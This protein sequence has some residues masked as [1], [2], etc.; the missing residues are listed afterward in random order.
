M[1]NNNRLLLLRSHI[2]TSHRYRYESVLKVNVRAILTKIKSFAWLS[3][4][5]H[6]FSS[7]DRQAQA[8]RRCCGEWRIEQRLLRLRDAVT[9]CRSIFVLL[10]EFRI[11]C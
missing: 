11:L 1:R 7:L 6:E 10:K 4:P 3:T 5:A 2:C 8:S 9:F